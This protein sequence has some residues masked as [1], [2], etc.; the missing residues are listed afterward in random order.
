[1][2][3]YNF[4]K[5]FLGIDEKDLHT[6][7]YKDLAELRMEVADFADLFVK[8]PGHIHNFQHVHWIDFITCAESN[9]ESKVIINA[10]SKSYRAIIT[11]TNAYLVDNPN[12]KAYFVY[13]NNL[14]ALTT[15]E[16]DNISGDIAQKPTPEVNPEKLQTITPR[17]EEITVIPDEYDKMLDVSTLELEE[18][19]PTV[20]PV[21]AY[22]VPE[23]KTTLSTKENY[24]FDPHIASKE[25]GLP[26]DL[27]EE[28]IQDF[29]EQANDFKDG[30]YTALDEGDINNVKILSHKL[31]GVAANLR[32]EDA[33]EILS[34]INVTSD[35]DVIKTNLDD[36]YQII[37]KLSGEE[38]STATNNDFIA[39]DDE[40]LEI[41]LED[42][43]DILEFK[44]GE[45]P[46]EIPAEITEET[47]LTL[48]LKEEQKPEAEYSKEKI[49]N[50]IGL[51]LENFNEL[52]DDFIK[53]AHSRFAKIKEALNNNDYKTSKMQAIKLKGMSDNMRV[54]AFTNEL[55]TLIDST[56]KT[57]ITE[58][59]Q[60]ID[61]IITKIS[62]KE[63]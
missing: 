33:Y 18:S 6:L 38:A 22:V 59:L 62:K 40:K 29:I 23:Q 50:E 34:V 57:A 9:E 43:E 44:E 49:A 5:E 36:F 60:Q 51:D 12:Q 47:E 31:K 21:K 20:E 17:K 16:Y 19:I 63:D 3:I 24:V 4:Q 42:M 15:Q 27:I 52:F 46:Q 30:L 54:H 61:S 32:I 13:L 41:N 45:A 7:G 48:E 55:E 14:R 1:M 53:E 35:V 58:A 8:T 25:L 28:F 2:L 26:L 39:P 56:D 11:V 10:N 37:A